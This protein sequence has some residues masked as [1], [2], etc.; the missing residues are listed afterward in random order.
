M[1][2]KMKVDDTPDDL[3]GY[4]SVD[5]E[6]PHR[7]WNSSLKSSGRRTGDR[8]DRGIYSAANAA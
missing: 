4:G 5:D 1:Q 8:D 7:Y 3:G 2:G 6:S